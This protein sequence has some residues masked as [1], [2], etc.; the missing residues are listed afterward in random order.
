MSTLYGTILVLCFD[1]V[2]S[3]ANNV[4]WLELELIKFLFTIKMPDSCSWMFPLSTAL[5]KLV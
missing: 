2:L 1:D 3:F 4:E 5:T